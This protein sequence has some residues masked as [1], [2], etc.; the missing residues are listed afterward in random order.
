[1]LGLGTARIPKVFKGL[2]PFL[3]TK[4]C[5]TKENISRTSSAVDVTI[6]TD[7]DLQGSLDAWFMATLIAAM[8]T[9]L[10]L[11]M[12]NITSIWSQKSVM[13][14]ETNHEGRR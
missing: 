11:V 3:L 10:D 7:S 9:P 12:P 5:W 13:P 2:Q 4:L 1:M 14:C 8:A 6:T